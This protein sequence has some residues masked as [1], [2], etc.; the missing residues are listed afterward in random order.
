MSTVS[1]VYPHQLFD[2]HPAL[3]PGQPVLLV[4]DPLFFGN[5]PDWPLAVHK[6]R[7]VLHRASMRRCWKWNCRKDVRAWNSPTRST[8]S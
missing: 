5:D 4:E 2:P 8:M 7:L 3:H 6:Q 1:L